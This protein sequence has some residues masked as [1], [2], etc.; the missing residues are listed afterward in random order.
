MVLRKL[1]EH[2]ARR[3]W[4]AV[5]IELLIVVIGVFLGLQAQEWSQQRADREREQAYIERLSA[6][7]EAIH[8]DLLRCRAVYR[9]SIEAIDTLSEA[10]AAQVASGAPPGEGDNSLSETL[11]RMTAGD[12]PAGRSTT[13]VEM[14]STGDLGILRNSALREALVAYDQRAQINREIWRSLREE[15]S[16]YMRPLYKHVQLDI[17]SDGDP[18]PS[19]AGYDLDAMS[20]DP[21]FRS[22]LNALIGVKANIG[23]LCFAQIK[24]VDRARVLL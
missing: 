5:A 17:D 21:G 4:L 18:T 9:G 3:N 11:I 14:L 16:G 19:I 6:D 20:R 13:F 1:V 24:L 10:L 8:Q 22:M 23:E 15:L 12:I 7:F 2:F